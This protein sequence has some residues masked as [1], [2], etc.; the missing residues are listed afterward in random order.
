MNFCGSSIAESFSSGILIGYEV[1]SSSFRYVFFC[2]ETK[3]LMPEIGII[4]SPFTV[5]TMKR[6]RN[7]P[8]LGRV[9]TLR[10]TGWVLA[11][12]R[13]CAFFKAVHSL[14]LSIG[15]RRYDRLL[16]SKAL[17]AY[18]SCAVMKII[19]ILSGAQERAS[20]LR[21][22]F[23]C[24]SAM[25]M[26]ASECE[27]KKWRASETVGIGPISRA[28]GIMSSSMCLSTLYWCISSSRINIFIFACFEL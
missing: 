11:V 9:G 15:L 25:M 23:S 20:K 21:P 14:S 26:S 3:Y 12:I 5:F 2:S 13:R 10:E 28:D 22:S 8:F 16:Y 19:G 17:R 6:S 24:I 7:F 18:S 1:V 4:F 27:R